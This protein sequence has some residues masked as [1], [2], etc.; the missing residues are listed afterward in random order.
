MKRE[1]RVVSF[2]SYDLMRR[3]THT[4]T[5][6]LIHTNALPV[7]GI[8]ISLSHPTDVLNDSYVHYTFLAHGIATNFIRS[9]VSTID[10][11]TMISCPAMRVTC[12]MG[13]CCL[14]F[15]L[16]VGVRKTWVV[17]RWATVGCVVRV[18]CR[19]R[20]TILHCSGNQIE[21]RSED[22]SFWFYCR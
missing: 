12:T 9:W 19:T 17:S 18:D 1:Q 10:D 20:M 8:T 14:F 4:S 7:S 11:G 6:S 5:H 2:W 22:F 21:E 13:H 16:V 15:T 3:V